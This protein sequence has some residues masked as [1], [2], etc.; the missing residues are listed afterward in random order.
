MVCYRVTKKKQGRRGSLNF[1]A[2][3]ALLCCAQLFLA[4]VR[5]G[6]SLVAVRWVLLQWFLLFQSTQ[7]STVVALG[8]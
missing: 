5:G 3:P 6:H 2:A 7:A 4:V 1:L 8:L